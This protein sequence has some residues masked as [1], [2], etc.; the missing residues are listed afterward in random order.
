MFDRLRTRLN[1]ILPRWV[2]GDT[3]HSQQ[4]SLLRILA[5][6]HSERLD[7]KRLIANLAVEHPGPYGRKLMN[8]QHWI[9]AGTPIGSALA[10]VPGALSAED[11]LAIQCGIENGTLGETLSFLLDRADRP[12]AVDTSQVIQKTVAYT[13]TTFL[14]ALIIVGFC[15]LFILPVFKEI[16]EEFGMELPWSFAALI[17]FTDT[18]GLVLVALFVVALLLGILI[19]FED[20]R[21]LF[22]HSPLS[23]WLPGTASRRRSGLLQLLAIPTQSGQPLGPTLTAAAQFHPDRSVR[24]GMLEVR[25][26]SQSDTDIWQQ[27]ARRGWI[28][29]NQSEQ[30]NVIT[31]PKLRAWA[32][33]TVAGQERQDVDQSESLLA[34]ILQYAP[35]LL[36]G[37]FVAWIATAIFQALTSI[38][39]ALA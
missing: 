12:E 31:D 8:L 19:Q 2:V 1:Y 39:L 36:L 37:L 3:L 17:K 34:Q 24:R 22:H 13:F 14:I 6:S 5:V 25:T 29:F 15:T 18:F 11:T 4:R 30:F 10:H 26:Q 27:L 20:V 35:V 7:P 9:A 32:L 33:C 21:R 16:F 28:S 38:I 23:R